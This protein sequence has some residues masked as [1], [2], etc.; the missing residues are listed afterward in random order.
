VGVGARRSQ[1]RYSAGERESDGSGS[2][3][4]GRKT[5]GNGVKP[6]SGHPIHR[7]STESIRCGSFHRTIHLNGSI[8][9]SSQEDPGRFLANRLQLRPKSEFRSSA[10]KTTSGRPDGKTF[11]KPLHHV[12]L[13][14]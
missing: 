8:P 10:K 1:D 2:D 5:K 14:L 9:R 3:S 4:D 12:N 13:G 7:G 11:C 6:A